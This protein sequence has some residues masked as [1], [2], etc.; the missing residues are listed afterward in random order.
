MGVDNVYRYPA[1]VQTSVCNNVTRF[2][3]FYAKVE[4]GRSGCIHAYISVT[5]QTGDFNFA[6]PVVQRL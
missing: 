1:H 6:G 2:I 3:A 4:Y 5:V